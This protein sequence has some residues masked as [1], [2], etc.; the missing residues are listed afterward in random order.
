M[1]HKRRGSLQ[2]ETVTPVGGKL[3][4]IC[5]ERPA[6]GSTVAPAT[7][8]VAPCGARD[9]LPIVVANTVTRS[10]NS[11]QNFRSGRAQLSWGNSH[12]RGVNVRKLLLQVPSP[13]EFHRTLAVRRP[14][15]KKKPLQNDFPSCFF[16]TLRDTS[17]DSNEDLSWELYAGDQ[18]EGFRLALSLDAMRY[19]DK[20]GELG[21]SQSH[22][23]VK[24]F[25]W[26]FS[27]S[28]ASRWA[29]H[30]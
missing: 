20:T 10:T 1:I 15:P 5:S 28:R 16:I 2:P 19:L 24:D 7:G 9:A 22:V 11:L 26:L 25:L 8:I 27:R 18:I 12:P 29:R 21:S 30:I 6:P 14:P 4:G 3:F 23:S 17:R 13:Y